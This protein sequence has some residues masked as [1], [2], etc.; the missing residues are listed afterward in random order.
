MKRDFAERNNFVKALLG[1]YHNEHVRPNHDEVHQL[2]DYINSTIA[3]NESL[4]RDE[5]GLNR[6]VLAAEAIR[7]AVDEIGLRGH[8]LTSYMLRS[9][10]RTAEQC[11]VIERFWQRHSQHLTRLYTR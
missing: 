9:V 1:I 2:A 3:T 7:L 10:V 5:F 8:A 6:I 11:D 4:I